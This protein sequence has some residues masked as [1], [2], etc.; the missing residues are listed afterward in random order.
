MQLSKFS[1]GLYKIINKIPSQSRQKQSLVG[2]KMKISIF[3][4]H[5]VKA[6]LGYYGPPQLQC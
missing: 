4:C 2:K 1:L 5:S 3:S 6:G